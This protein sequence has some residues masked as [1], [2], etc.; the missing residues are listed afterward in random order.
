MVHGAQAQ[1]R[2]H[3]LVRA[4][5]PGDDAVL[6]ARRPRRQGPDERHRQGQGRG[7]HVRRG[8]RQDP[9]G[10]RRQRRTASTSA[11]ASTARRP[12]PPRRP[13]SAPRS[14]RSRRPRPRPRSPAPRR[15]P[16]RPSR[17]SPR[18][19]R[20]PRRPPRP[21]RRRSRRRPR[22]KTT[23]AAKPAVAVDPSARLLA[24]LAR[25]RRW[26]SSST[27]GAPT[28][29]PPAR[30]STRPR[31][32]DPKH[33]V[34][35]YVPI[36]KVGQYE[37]ITSDVDVLAAPTILV[38]STKGKA[39]PLT[40]Y[41]DAAVVRNAVSDAP[42]RPRPRPASSGSRRRIRG[43]MSR[44]HLDVLALREQSRRRARRPAARSRAAASSSDAIVPDTPG[45]RA[46]HYRPDG[47]A[48]RPLLV[49]LHGGFWVLGELGEPR[50]ALPP[51]RRRGRHRG[52]RRRLPPAR[53]STPGPP[54]STTPS[55]P[56]RWASSWLR[57]AASRSRSA[58]TPPAAASRRWPR[59]GCA[60]PEPRPARRS[61]SA[62]TPT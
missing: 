17:P 27:A 45:V 18:R 9:D 32:G 2:G 13:R 29:R 59:C 53:P 6:G 37:A 20:P 10:D 24:Y 56:S 12:R 46:R 50:P 14:P 47:A 34:S 38:I 51:D 41:V 61:C 21:P 42:A 35:A 3:Q 44:M 48:R 54:R 25:A 58:A 57:G 5:R 4:R 33:V 7:G 28:T 15:R 11:P 23:A 26:S 62:P 55:P 16:P 43:I 30:P 39:T 19:R 52:A 60:T 1:V 36:S 31:K 8:Q 40:G 22:P 49:Y